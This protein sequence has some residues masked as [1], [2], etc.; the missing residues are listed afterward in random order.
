M[1]TLENVTKSYPVR[2]G[3]HVVLKD[4]SIEFPTNKSVGILGVNGAGK[5]TLLR[6]LAGVETP[7]TG[8]II[9]R[10]RISW[11]IGFGGGFNSSLSGEE[12]CRFVS[13]IY[14]EDID[15]VTS[16]AY[17]FS[18]LGKF[19]YMP[20]RTY[21]SGMRSR[22]AFGLSMAIDFDC[23][24]VDEVTAVGD[25]KFNQK[26]KAAFDE[27]RERSIVLMVSHSMKTIREYCDHFAV[28]NNGKLRMFENLK[29]AE[30]SYDG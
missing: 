9:R 3:R 22:L 1:I 13:R 5:S 16:F 30:R 18:E 20:V 19:F 15:R 8:A 2:H 23:Y 29:V 7:D 4:I 21:S 25:K 27:R 12:N 26:C 6:L 17:E 11:P 24:L 10:G 28:L 14:D